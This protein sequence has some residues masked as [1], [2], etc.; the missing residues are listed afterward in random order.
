MQDDVVPSRPVQKNLAEV[1]VRQ[2]AQQLSGATQLCGKECRS[3][4][5]A[6]N[7]DCTVLCEHFLVVQR[8]VFH[9]G[10]DIDVVVPHHEESLHETHS[11]QHV[12]A[13]SSC[14]SEVDEI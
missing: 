4:G 8:N 3:H 10:R 14:R 11:I 6:A 7:A 1:V 13:S 9:L 5:I 12:S 2:L